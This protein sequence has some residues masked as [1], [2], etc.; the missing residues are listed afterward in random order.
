MRLVWTQAA[1]MIKE[2]QG[3]ELPGD[4]FT[5]LAATRCPRKTAPETDPSAANAAGPEPSQGILDQDAP[6][7]RCVELAVPYRLVDTVETLRH[8]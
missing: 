8:M 1:A 6:R 5:T 3:T 7:E 4:A 2:W